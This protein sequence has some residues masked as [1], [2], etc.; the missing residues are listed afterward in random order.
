MA[1]CHNCL[2]PI[3]ETPYWECPACSW[4]LCWGC[5]QFG[6]AH[7]C[8]PGERPPLCPEC[9][10]WGE[11]SA[12]GGPYDYHICP[13]CNGEGFDVDADIEWRPEE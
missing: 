8:V 3:G 10:G 1:T 2:V 7:D 4:T 9:D 12:D 11:V 6:R 13:R 5:E